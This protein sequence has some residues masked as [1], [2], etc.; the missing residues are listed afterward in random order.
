MLVQNLIDL[1]NLEADELLDE[2]TD[3]I[4]Y[5]NSAI[6]YL[7]FILAGLGSSDCMNTKQIWDYLPVPSDFIEFVPKNGY[8]IYIDN[9]VFYTNGKTITAKYSIAK[10][11]ISVVTDTIPFKDMYA[12]TL[13]LIASYM[14]K[15]KSYIPVEYTSSDKGFIA[16]VLNSIK[17]AKGGN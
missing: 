4:P 10:P 14:I 15:K 6:D 8:P 1:I 2:D 7:S 9:N 5:I 13:V 17:A 3:N 16:D 12:S 11:H